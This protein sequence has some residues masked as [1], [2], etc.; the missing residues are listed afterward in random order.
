MGGAEHWRLFLAGD[1]NPMASNLAWHLGGAL[2]L[3]LLGLALSRNLPAVLVAG[4]AFNI[5]HEYVSEGRYVDPSCIDLWFGQTALAV[6][7]ALW[8]AMRGRR[9]A[10]SRRATR[11]ARVEC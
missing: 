6:A 9:R 10:H 11:I 8:L 7:A 1:G 3:A 2:A 4:T 5:W